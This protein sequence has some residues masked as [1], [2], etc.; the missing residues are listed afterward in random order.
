MTALKERRTRRTIVGATIALALVIAAS[1]M[2]TIGVITLSNSK[3][4]E[5]VGLDPRPRVQLPATPNALLAITDDDGSLASAV[6]LTL[7]P[8]GQGGSIVVIPAAAD[9]TAGFGLQRRPLDEV[10][11]PGDPEGL[12]T[13]VEDMLSITVERAEIVDPAGLAILLEPIGAVQV[14]LPD[15]MVESADADDGSTEDT[16]ATTD[17][18]D[19][20][21]APA[22]TEDA[23]GT[24]DA[25]PETSDPDVVVSAGPQLLETDEI[26]EVLSSVDPTRSPMADYEMDVAVWSAIGETAPL[27]VPAEPVTTD[28][29]GAPTS[30]TS[31]AELL[32]RL[33]EGDVGVREIAATEPGEETNPTGVEVLVLDRPDVNLVF[34]Q[35]S[36]ALVSTPNT[37]LKTR[38]VVGYTDD[39]LDSGGGIYDS[40]ADV[41]RGII[42]QLLFLQGN[43]VSVDT[44]PTGA[45]EVNVIEVADSRWLEDTQAAAELLFG[46][47][48]VSVATTVIEGV[49]VEVVLGTAYLDRLGGSADEGADGTVPDDTVAADE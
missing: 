20:T 44:S 4:G 23:P 3:E 37:G 9:T 27:T 29:A 48:D 38:V 35:V 21:D 28:D 14:V 19:T 11:D 10:Y 41:A 15:A 33:W 5:A 25:A 24:T 6:V 8:D 32:E 39:Q 46:P 26:V 30:P 22:T 42:G 34:A 17:A 40:N 16:P 1:A 13:A 43:V 31:V 45:A 18:P 7:L 36:P 12:T 2:F 49:D 47:S